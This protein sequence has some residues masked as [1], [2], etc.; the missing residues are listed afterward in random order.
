MIPKSELRTKN[1]LL[2]N[3]YYF[4]RSGRSFGVWDFVASNKKEILFIQSKLRQMPSSEEMQRLRD[5]NN[6]PESGIVK[7][8]IWLW[9]DGIREPRITDLSGVGNVSI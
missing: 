5:F 9:K 3:G 4:I 1:H 8:Q 7:R 6:Y 2:K